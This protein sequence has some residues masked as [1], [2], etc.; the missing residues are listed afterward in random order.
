[1]ARR[2][3]WVTVLL[4]ISI[5]AVMSACMY[6]LAPWIIGLLSPDAQVVALGTEVLRIV[7]FAE[8]LFGAAMVCA[9]VFQGAGS[10]LL[11]SVLNFASMWG[12]RIPLTLLLT[13][14]LGLHGAWVAMC[15]ELCF[16]GVLFL[17]CL[18]RKF[19][20]PKDLREPVQR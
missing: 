11:S 1:M 10:S 15:I 19:W 18:W 9:G 2:L 17:F 6:V 13:S 20:L 5:M 12:V 16:R 3:G 8:P 4:G 7:V 14:R